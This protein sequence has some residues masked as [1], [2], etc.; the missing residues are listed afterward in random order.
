MFGRRHSFG[1]GKFSGK[2][3]RFVDEHRKML[4]TDPYLLITVQHIDEGNLL[5]RLFAEKTGGNWLRHG[6]VSLYVIPVEERSEDRSVVLWYIGGAFRWCFISHPIG[7]CSIY[8]R[9]ACNS[10]PLRIIRS[11]KRGCQTWIPGCFLWA[12]M[13]TA[14]LKFL[15]TSDND[16]SFNVNV[17]FF[18]VL[19]S[20]GLSIWIIACRWSGIMTNWSNDTYDNLRGRFCKHSNI[21][22]LI[23]DTSMMPLPILPKYFFLLYVHR[24]TKY[25]LVDA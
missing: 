15:T 10:C 4:R 23:S 8:F 11:W 14:D 9:I 20:S 12:N 3:M 25:R 13:V 6:I 24:V 21:I 19:S 2:H 22:W 1:T 5:L 16:R 17:F 18:T 7:L